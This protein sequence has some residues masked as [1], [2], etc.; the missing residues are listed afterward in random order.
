M[1]LGSCRRRFREAYLFVLRRSPGQVDVQI[2][3][4]EDTGKVKCWMDVFLVKLCMTSRWQ[5]S[6][7]RPWRLWL[8]HCVRIRRELKE[9][10]ELHSWMR[11][12][13]E[14]DVRWE[15]LWLLWAHLERVP[16]VLVGYDTGSVAWI[17][18]N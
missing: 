10:Y 5:Y 1:F 8:R 7:G 13:T 9:Y 11:Q 2:V 6:G 17:E 4:G 16:D 14:R 18:G 12:F 3:F 15:P